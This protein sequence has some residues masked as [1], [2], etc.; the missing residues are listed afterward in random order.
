MADIKFSVIVDTATGQAAIKQFDGD[1]K[2]LG[3]SGE[4]SGLSFSKLSGGIAAGVAAYHAAS[5]A[6]SGLTGFMKSCIDGAIESEQAES[7]LASTLMITGREVDKNKK[8][9]LDYATQMQAVTKFT[10]EEV[11]AS[12]TLLLQLTNLDQKGIDAAEKGAIGLASTLKID[13]QSATMMVAK[14]MEGNFAALGRYGIKIKETGDLEKDRAALL[15]KLGA[16]YKRAEDEVNTF[17]GGLGQLKKAYD[18]LKEEIGKVVTQSEDFKDIIAIMTT[19]IKDFATLL[20]SDVGGGMNLIEKSFK[21]VNNLIVGHFGP[22]LMLLRLEA[23]KTSHEE[24]MAEAVT[25]GLKKS[26]EEF[27]KILNKNKIDLSGIIPYWDLLKQKEGEASKPLVD[28][29]KIAKDAS[30]TLRTDLIK[31]LNNME[32]ALKTLGPTGLISSKGT[33]ELK[34]KI[35]D[36]RLELGLISPA[37]YAVCKAIDEG[38][39]RHEKLK[40]VLIEETLLETKLGKAH[41]DV[42]NI[43]MLANLAITKSDKEMV[44][45]LKLDWQEMMALNQMWGNSND[46][47]RQ[48][49]AEFAAKIL[50][51]FDNLKINMADGFVEVGLGHKSFLDGV[52]GSIETFGN[53]VGAAT[54]KWMM[55]LAFQEAFELIKNQA[56][57]IAG[58]LASVFTRIPFPFSIA[59]AGAAIAAVTALF[60]KI[61]GFEEGGI[62]FRPT[63]GMLGERGP[64]AV[65]PLNQ[66]TINNYFGRQSSARRS[67]T[68]NLDVYLGT[69]LFERRVIKIVERNSDL[70]TLRVHPK[71]I[72]TR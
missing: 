11:A 20:K 8:H 70:G 13:L 38:K 39:V 53:E 61:R 16:M 52:K 1:V 35:A 21:A 17:G 63:M 64:E 34:N 62:V 7:A 33:E 40:P 67:E 42:A 25:W 72:R 14:A 58:V 71:A 31:Q 28:F 66:N 26:W 15:D 18:E 24:K 6:V 41:K 36:L 43:I 65:I 32:T 69:E 54:R 4:K 47:L 56:R 51:S 19:A 48:N 60:A 57:A 27:N 30:V 3:E 22:A 49:Y 12:Q 10:D 44:K 29:E 37:W 5:K 55:D 9:F 68:I 59:A 23:A 2:K 45:L 50:Q 46:I